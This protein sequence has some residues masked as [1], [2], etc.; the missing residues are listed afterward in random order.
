MAKQM[1]SESE[2]A[3]ARKEPTDF[4]E[5]GEKKPESGND[6][7][8]VE[9]EDKKPESGN[10]DKVVVKKEPAEP[11][12]Q[13]RQKPGNQTIV[14]STATPLS[15]LLMGPLAKKSECSGVVLHLFAKALELY[16]HEYA[17]PGGSIFSDQGHS[18][19]FEESG[20][21][22]V[23]CMPRSLCLNYYG[24]VTLVP[25]EGCLPLC[26]A[27]GLEWYLDG[28]GVK[29]TSSPFGCVAW[30]IKEGKKKKKVSTQTKSQEKPQ[31][32]G[33]EE[34][35]KEEEKAPEKPE[36]KVQEKVP[37]EKVGGYTNAWFGICLVSPRGLRPG[38]PMGPRGAP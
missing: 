17:L 5:P 26:K 12:P 1:L 27:F 37:E 24:N 28:R 31:E 35:A 2:E 29:G 34:G 14:G 13:E 32:K 3:G 33:Q 20:R 11:N 18:Y 23:N 19:I 25:V 36:E 7:K 21:L 15:D 38:G 30:L 6:E 16:I 8:V 10:A 4:K 22:K 9:L